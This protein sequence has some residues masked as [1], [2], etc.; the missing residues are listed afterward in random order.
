M[1]DIPVSLISFTMDGTQYLFT[2]GY[3]GAGG[4]EGSFRY[5][6]DT[7]L[8]AR[9]ADNSSVSIY[10]RFRTTSPIAGTFTDGSTSPCFSFSNDTW[11]HD[12]SDLDD[13]TFIIT[14]YGDVGGVIKGTFSGQIQ[15]PA[16]PRAITN[17][18]FVIERKADNTVGSGE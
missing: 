5:N 4:A 17:G 15:Q 7:F 14:E 16:P 13:F 18:I 12:N 1:G 8:A 9:S 2:E 11:Y 10:L 3:D 6:G